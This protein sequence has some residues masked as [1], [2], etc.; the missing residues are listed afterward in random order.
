MTKKS[1]KKITGKILLFFVL[2]FF[3]AGVAFGPISSTGGAETAYAAEVTASEGLECFKGL[4]I[5]FDHCAA[6]VGF[7]VFFI[8]ATWLLVAATTVFDTMIMFSLSNQ[9][10]DQQF[11]TDAW[12][13]VRDVANM[14]FI[15]VLLYIAIATILN[16]GNYKKLLV[17]LVIV[18]LVINFSAFFTKIVIDASNI[19]ALGFYN[20][21]DA[22][23]I[24]ST[25]DPFKNDIG[26]KKQSIS[27]VFIQGFDVQNIAGKET[28]EKWRQG[29]EN[30]SMLFFVFLAAGIVTIVASFV[31][32]AAGFLFLGRMVAFWFLII[33]SPIAFVAMIL[34]G[35]RGLFQKWWDILIGQ[36]LIAPVFLFFMYVIAM[37]VK[38]G[39][40]GNIFKSGGENP[41]DIII[42]IIV[43]FLVLLITL[44][45][46]LD[47]TKKLSGQIG[48]L[49]SK[50]AGGDWAIKQ[51]KAVGRFAR[52][53]TVGRG[54]SRVA[55]SRAMKTL[56]RK[57]PGIGMLAT[58][59]L[60]KMGGASYNKYA[61]EQAKKKIA[62]GARVSGISRGEGRRIIKDKEKL[63]LQNRTGKIS[64]A[65]LKKQLGYIERAEKMTTGARKMAMAT[66]FGK[67]GVIKRITGQDISEREVA[68]KIRKGEKGDDPQVENFKKFLKAEEQK[69][70]EK[71][72]GE[73]KPGK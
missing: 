51:T 66:A 19:F 31:L 61:S 68:K 23:P 33:A 18:A 59:G 20:A 56:G 72:A 69:K 65:E 11:V 55:D 27:T 49:T 26:V 24:D 42:N 13:A 28:F 37:I 29:G 21:I 48:A 12:K 67:S 5:Q 41:M 7:Y 39:F 9:M 30:V 47:V 35:A 16:L 1:V 43:A 54:M 34:P 36:A 15:F 44:M 32:F 71:P 46:A 4:S 60:D 3:V 6:L 45:M 10:L 63:E 2:F 25:E 64:N 73:Y 53:Q 70:T 38:D 52:T 57:V 40:I 22:P 58:A 8:P 17:N 50:Y 14:A 62:Y